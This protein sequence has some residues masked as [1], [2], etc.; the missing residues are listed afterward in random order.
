[1]AR[2]AD[3]HARS[4]LIAA[5][6]REFRRS[7]IQRARIEDITQACGLSKGAFYLH[8][9]SKEALFREVVAGL[10]THFDEVRERREQAYLE[11]I[12]AVPKSKMNAI[13]TRLADVDAEGDRRLLELLWEWRDVADVLLR[14][15]Q[16]T[17]FEGVMWLM[18]DAEAQR[19]AEQ[20][21]A[22]GR[23]KLV[24]ADVPAELV[25]MMIVG[26]YLMV[27][28]RIALAT[29][30]PD[31]EPWVRSLQSLIA[32]GIAA[33]GSPAVAITRAAA[34]RVNGRKKTA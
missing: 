3:P 25:G 24:R 15:S 30:K 5:A 7:G 28:R 4:A 10:Q 17:E 33:K 32:E 23:A 14:G 29:Q 13:V 11:L 6:R 21:G 8:F 31:F 26:T 18:L 9:A 1:M 22:L 20:C 2:P 27:A 16:G 34:K 19:V 12:S